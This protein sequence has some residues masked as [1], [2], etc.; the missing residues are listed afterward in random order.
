MDAFDGRFRS[1][2]KADAATQIYP[3]SVLPGKLRAGWMS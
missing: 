2:H 3:G 1:R